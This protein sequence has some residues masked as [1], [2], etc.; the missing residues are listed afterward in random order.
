[1]LATFGLERLEAGLINDMDSDAEVME[2]L[3][4]AEA[5]KAEA[6][7]RAVVRR[8]PDDREETALPTRLYVHHRPNPQFRPTPHVNRV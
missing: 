3:Q 1:M 5:E 8:A 4:Q 6:P 7:A 2:W